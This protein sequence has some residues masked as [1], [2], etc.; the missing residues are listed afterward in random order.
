LAAGRTPTR[1][2]KLDAVREILRS[3]GRS[4][5]QGA[6]AWIWARSDRT[7]PIPGFKTVAQ[8]EDN[9][10]A[11]GVRSAHGGAD[12]RDRNPAEPAS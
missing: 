12:D 7:I 11:Q 1:S 5:A 3:E 8:V 2:R 6:L 9:A 4:L 10:G